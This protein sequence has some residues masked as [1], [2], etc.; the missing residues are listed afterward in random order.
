MEYGLPDVKASKAVLYVMLLYEFWGTAFWVMAF[1]YSYNN[2]F[3]RGVTY[4]VLWII[5]STTTGAHFNPALSL[6]VWMS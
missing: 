2:Y 4:S 1:N 6:A 3:V 5:C